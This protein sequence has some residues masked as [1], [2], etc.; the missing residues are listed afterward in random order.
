MI[1]LSLRQHVYYL[2][3]HGQIIIC[4]KNLHVFQNNVE[5]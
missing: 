5:G 3:D 4:Y 2:T 1:F